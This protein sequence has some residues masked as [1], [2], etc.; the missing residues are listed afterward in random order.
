MTSIESPIIALFL[1]FI[2][3]SLIIV[4][5]RPLRGIIGLSGV[6]V[7]SLILS[8]WIFPEE[9]F[10]PEISLIIK[11][12]LGLKII[13]EIILGLTLGMLLSLIFEIIPFIGRLIDT[14]RGVQFAEQ[15]APELGTRDS[16]LESY[17]GYLVIWFF[18]SGVYIKEWIW[19]LVKIESSY[20]L[21]TVFNHDLKLSSGVLFKDR[22]MIESFVGEFFTSTL[23]ILVPLILL[24]LGF[25]LVLSILQ[26]LNSKFNIGFELC[27][28]RAGMG[29]FFLSYLV[30]SGT[31]A[32]EMLQALTKSGI[33][34]LNQVVFGV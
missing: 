22:V 3:H 28:L 34:L 1:L 30:Y 14:F 24:S 5:I 23:L 12:D 21:Y 10:L 33:V 18:F 11:S 16:L 8:I 2:R 7:F 17:G 6:F 9:V 13:K 15:V 19:L 4:C 20:P 29:V 25:E 31:Q 26:K 27:L 32:P